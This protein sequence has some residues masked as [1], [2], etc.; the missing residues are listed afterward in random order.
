VSAVVDGLVVV[1][2]L[3]L[4]CGSVAGWWWLLDWVYGKV[5]PS[6]ERWIWRPGWRRR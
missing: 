3:V 1:L 5:K 6:L 4:I 2:I